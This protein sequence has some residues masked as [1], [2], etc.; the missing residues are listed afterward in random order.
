MRLIAEENKTTYRAH[1]SP[2]A[3][4]KRGK[5]LVHGQRDVTAPFKELSQI[6]PDTLGG[7]GE[8]E[9]ED[10]DTEKV[11][12]GRVLLQ[13]SESYCEFR[14]PV[15]EKRGNRKR[16]GAERSRRKEERSYHNP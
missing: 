7:G 5:S 16:K 3:R 13:S 9:R 8:M 15:A 1:Q 10:G 2:P 12:A 6:H 4:E 14:G 11:R